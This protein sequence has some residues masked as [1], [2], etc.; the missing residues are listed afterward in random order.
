MSKGSWGGSAAGGGLE[1]QAAVSALCMVHM[2]RGT[3]L[4]WVD[5]GGDTPLS[6]SAETGGAGDDIALQ[7]ASGSILEIQAKRKLQANSEL[8]D[9]LVSLCR[10]AYEDM[11]FYG[12]LAVGPT[13]SATIRDQLA[14]DII[15]IGQGRKDDLSPHAVTFTKKLSEALIPLSAS[16]RVRI[17]TLHLLEQDGA[18][19]QSALAQLAHITVQPDQAWE[20][21]RTEGLRLIKLRGRQDTVSIAGIIPGLQS[22]TS[23]SRAPSVVANQL[24]EWTLN[25]TGS[26]TIPAV[27]KLFS[28]DDDW[29]ELEAYSQDEEVSLGNLEEALTNYHEGGAKKKA[30]LEQNKYSAESLG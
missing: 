4:G 3:P 23:G 2:A 22:N 16:N 7:L 24:L 18:S 28:L 27:N 14:R 13:T 1:F 30:G 11:T 21:L 17:Q 26:F 10:R 5:S 8:W 20:R 15:R 6:V 9:A 19:T 25:I 29:I 12:V